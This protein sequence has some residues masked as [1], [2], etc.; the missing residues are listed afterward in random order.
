MRAGALP[1]CGEFG[2]HEAQG[3]ELVNFD[4]YN[5]SAE[6]L[7]QAWPPTLYDYE[8][9]PSDSRFHQYGRPPNLKY[10]FC[11]K[12]LPLSPFSFQFW[13]QLGSLQPLKPSNT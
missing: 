7:L 1:S 6:N 10:V 2:N 5:A 4:M 9:R 11:G 13:C 3:G 8:A 12:H